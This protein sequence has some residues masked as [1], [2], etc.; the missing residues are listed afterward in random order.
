MLSFQ[1][2]AEKEDAV[3]VKTDPVAE[4]EESPS[5]IHK[6]KKESTMEELSSPIMPR[7]AMPSQENAPESMPAKEITKEATEEAVEGSISKH[8]DC[9]RVCIYQYLSFFISLKFQGQPY[10]E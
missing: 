5:T 7:R 8:M 4:I 2:K 9:D 10:K 3:D 1:Q 6:E